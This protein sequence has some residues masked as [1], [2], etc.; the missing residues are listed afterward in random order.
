MW[1]VS[2]LR[3][4]CTAAFLGAVAVASG[5]LRWL[6]TEYDFGTWREASGPRTGV[7]KAVNEGPDTVIITR[8][9]PSCGCTAAG[10]DRDPIAPGDTTTVS[11]TY[12]PARRPGTFAKTVRVYIAGQDSPTIIHIRGTIVGTPASLAADYPIEYGALRLATDHVALPATPYGKNSYGVLRGYNQSDDTVKMNLVVHGPDD[13]LSADMAA[14]NVPPGEVFAISFCLNGA[15]ALPGLNS[16]LVE[17]CGQSRGKDCYIVAVDGEVQTPVARMT[18]GQ[19]ASAPRL[20]LP[21]TLVELPAPKAGKNTVKFR[22]KVENNGK[23][24]LTFTRVYSRSD[25]VKILS[26]PTVL[27]PG[28]HA[29]ITGEVLLDRLADEATVY[30]LDVELVT[31]DPHTPV[32]TVR[33]A[34]RR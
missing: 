9:K 7:V 1:R 21:A 34:G 2:H 29:E 33:L 13:A 6:S 30:G 12:D 27:K 16:Y 15:V 3:A 32:T 14:K 19:L 11:F 18:A 25:A 23:T 17:V 5:Q 8:V 24:P 10:Y 22:F 4:V 20:Y 31:N 28:R 26:H